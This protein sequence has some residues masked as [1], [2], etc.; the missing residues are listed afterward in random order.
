MQGA[1]MEIEK[2]LTGREM[3]MWLTMSVGGSV[4]KTGK[5]EKG[6]NGV[7][8]MVRRHRHCTGMLLLLRHPGYGT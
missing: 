5:T 1:G 4:G 8:G 7:G 3:G 2:G 6:E